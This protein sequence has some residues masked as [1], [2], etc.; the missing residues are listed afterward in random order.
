ML[1]RGKVFIQTVSPSVFLVINLV[2]NQLTRKLHVKNIPNI[3]KI[4][5]LFFY[6][7][8]LLILSIV[9]FWLNSPLVTFSIYI[10]FIN[11]N[12]PLICSIFNSDKFR[13]MKVNKFRRIRFL[14]W[15]ISYCN[16]LLL[17]GV[18]FL[19]L[20]ILVNLCDNN[21]VHLIDSL[22]LFILVLEL[23]IT[24]VLKSISGSILAL[25]HVL[26]FFIINF[27]FLN[28]LSKYT[29]FF[30][31]SLL[32]Y[33]LSKNTTVYL[34]PRK[35]YTL[36]YLRKSLLTTFLYI[37]IFKNIK[38]KFFI[39]IPGITAPLISSYLG[40][41]FTPSIIILLMLLIQ[42]EI[43]ID[44]EIENF[45][46]P[47][48]KIKFLKTLKV[49]ILKRFLLSIYFRLNF[50]TMFIIWIVNFFNTKS[51]I[52]FTL[53]SI[54]ESCFIACM[55]LYY[56]FFSER[57]LLTHLHINAILREFIPITVILIFFVF[58]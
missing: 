12:L 46:I 50:I 49:S 44:T 5:L 19:F 42:F 23:T 55:A 48:A 7:L 38:E 58:M 57:E 31:I 13:A 3:V 2:L 37:L 27:L 47:I 8:F 54:I 39:L 56:Y 36:S 11:F 4:F 32:I 14:I 43:I 17:S 52:T 29:F 25:L 10:L 18:L 53:Q 16:P 28:P 6:L 21:I 45:E 30:T 20:S 15:T 22:I 26:L 51:F 41:T 35:N 40:A 9:D 33:L 24:E 34:H 1:Q